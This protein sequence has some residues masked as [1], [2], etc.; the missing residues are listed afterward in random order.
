MKNII[1]SGII[2]LSMVMAYCNRKINDNTEAE[3]LYAKWEVKSIENIDNGSVQQKVNQELSS[4]SIMGIPVLGIFSNL[5]QEIN[6][7][8]NREASRNIIIQ[9]E[10]D[11]ITAY[12]SIG[13]IIDERALSITRKIDDHTY[14]VLCNGE[15]GKISIEPNGTNIKLEFP[16][17]IFHLAKH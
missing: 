17:R 9:I 3:T 8:N 15:E 12:N 6:R 7:D 16:H 5:T 10:K 4:D 11:K 2:M 14:Q 1:T 13:E